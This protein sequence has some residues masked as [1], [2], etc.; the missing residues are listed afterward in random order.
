MRCG[1]SLYIQGYQDW[2]RY[3][4]AERGEQVAPLDPAED[5]KRYAEELDTA[6]LFEEQ[7]F[8]TIWTVEH[9][10]M[11]YTMVTNPLQLLTFFAGATS[12]IDVGSMV[13]VPPWHHPIRIAE[14]MTMLQYALRGRN[15]FIGFGR[16]AARREF[17]Q[18]GFNM[19]ESRDR[20]AE[21]V[22]IVKKALTEECFSHEGRHYQY[23]RVTMRPRPRDAAALINNFQFSWGTPSSA[24]LGAK[25][26][27]NPMI[28]PQKAFSEYHEDLAL[29]GK[30]RAEI[31]LPPTRPRIHVICY[32][33]ETEE[34]ARRNAEIYI[35]EY[36]DSATRAYE[37]HSGHF[38]KVKGYERYAER[39][40]NSG[41]Q[42]NLAKSMAK[43]YMDNHIWGTP[44]MCLAKLRKLAEDFHAEEFMLVMRVGNMP[45]DVSDKSIALFAKEVLPALHAMETLPPLSY[46]DA[47]PTSLLASA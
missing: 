9:H 5:A 17:K 43:V 21:S 30:A 10:I 34:E 8:D 27:L 18:L 39:A 3:E 24:P 36:A 1:V 16:G 42:Q 4:A 6:L 44:E 40:R 33:A 19:D 25:L 13:V 35:P 38:E 22:E 41:G 12:R 47:A 23:E 32:C 11:P 7:G 31:G 2:E 28:V 26:G 45:K 29:F 37:L 20:F 14:D 15:A 46:E